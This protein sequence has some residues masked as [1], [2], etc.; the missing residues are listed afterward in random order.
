MDFETLNEKIY[1]IYDKK[2]YFSKYGGSLF[3]T[4]LILIISFLIISYYYVM[5]RVEPIKNDWLN[6]R[7]NPEV[8]PFAGFI[9]KPKNMSAGEFTSQNFEQCL[10]NTLINI[11]DSFF[12]PILYNLQNIQGSANI[13]M[14]SLNRMAK[15]VFG[16]F[17]FDTCDSDTQD[18]ILKR[19]QE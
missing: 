6:Q 18:R 3:M 1:N 4:F 13:N 19:I 7:C 8:M 9:N 14:D 10:N 5:N 2:G 17:G 12:Q 11:V 15:Y 16:E